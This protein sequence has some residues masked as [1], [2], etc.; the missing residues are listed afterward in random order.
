MSAA[1]SGE[2]A[3]TG[4]VSCTP[5]GWTTPSTTI[6]LKMLGRKRLAGGT[7]DRPA[8]PGAVLLVAAGSVFLDAAVR[9]AVGFPPSGPVPVARPAVPAPQTAKIATAA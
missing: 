9:P 7:V 1:Y 2:F 6:V 3:T 8:V 4:H 5:G